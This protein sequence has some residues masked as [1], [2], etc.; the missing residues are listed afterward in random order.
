MKRAIGQTRGRRRILASYAHDARLRIQNTEL[1]AL[2]SLR[3][4]LEQALGL[5]F[6]GER[7]EH[8]FRSTFIQTLFYVFFSAWV[9]WARNR[10]AKIAT[11]PGFQ[12]GLHDSSA[13][14]GAQG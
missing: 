3:D 4:A 9:L 5:H 1:P 13:S 10:P 6:E 7:G 14:Y 11:L 2:Q 8:F 12:Q